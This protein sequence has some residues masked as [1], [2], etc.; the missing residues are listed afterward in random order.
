M[1]NWEKSLVPGILVLSLPSPYSLLRFHGF[2]IIDK[3]TLRDRFEWRK[4]KKN[5]LL[6]ISG[7]Q[8]PL[9]SDF[10]IDHFL[11]ATIFFFFSCS[12]IVYSIALLWEPRKLKR[13]CLLNLL[14]KDLKA[15]EQILYCYVPFLDNQNSIYSPSVTAVMRCFSVIIFC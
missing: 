15:R 10:V 9:R 11:V 12:L 3:L 1:G 7:L 2:P 5:N 6:Y 13:L 4:E 8:A 14:V